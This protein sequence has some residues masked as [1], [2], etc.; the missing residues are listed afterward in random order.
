MYL[1]FEPALAP[2]AAFTNEL[3]PRIKAEPGFKG[4]CWLY[5]AGQ[6][7]GLVLFEEAQARLA[8]A[9]ERWKAPDVAVERLEV[10]RV[11]ATA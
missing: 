5:P 3:L 11:A 1:T 2:A 9:S 8:S 10:R 7:F 4:G 6:G